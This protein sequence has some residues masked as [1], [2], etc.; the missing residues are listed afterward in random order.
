MKAVV[1]NP[2]SFGFSHAVFDAIL[3]ITI[4]EKIK[5]MTKKI[6]FLGEKEHVSEVQNILGSYSKN[7]K[8]IGYKKHGEE[9]LAITLIF[10]QIY[11]KLA[12]LKKK[13]ERVLEFFSAAD[14]T[15]TPFYL[16]YFCSG[17]S[18][19]YIPPVIFSHN[20]LQSI[21]RKTVKGQ[22]WKRA[23][24]DSG[25]KIM[26]LETDLFKKSKSMLSCY[27]I[28]EIEHPTYNNLD[29][30][31]R[32]RQIR[33]RASL[34]Y[35]FLLIGRHGRKK[36]NVDELVRITEEVIDK[37]ENNII[38]REIHIGFTGSSLNILK[39]KSEIKIIALGEYPK[40]DDYLKA[41]AR[42]KFVVFPSS[43]G[44]RLTAS[45]T[46]ADALSVGTPIIAPAKGGFKSIT[47]Y[48]EKFNQFFYENEEGLKNALKTAITIQNSEYKS[49]TGVIESVAIRNLN[50]FKNAVYFAMREYL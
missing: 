11:L 8:F 34:L 14:N 31:K 33:Q 3:L 43:A 19:N 9:R 36:E 38:N 2:L 16:K 48:F 1:V 25:A 5:K 44:C 37:M 42:T 13:N 50:K 18:K 41:I 40:L 39:K 29:S 45:G 10:I 26:A 27:K 21:V 7:I 30:Y 35:D 24:D 6:Y 23:L 46:L 17:L 20:N 22:R 12:S 4:L 47:K 32:A 15:I 28:S 49:L